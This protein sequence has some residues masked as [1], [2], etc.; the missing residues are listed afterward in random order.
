MASL[1]SVIV[2]GKLLFKL[3]LDPSPVPYVRSTLCAA[4]HMYLA[5]LNFCLK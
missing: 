4:S 1:V 2:L 5:V 3:P